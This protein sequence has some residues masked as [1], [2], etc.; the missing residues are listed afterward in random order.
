MQSGA[1][2][3]E[4]WTGRRPTSDEPSRPR[5]FAGYDDEPQGVGHA[6]TSNADVADGFSREGA[7]PNLETFVAR[8]KVA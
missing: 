5:P 8:K 6:A 1:E 3:D 2:Q 4:R 7:D